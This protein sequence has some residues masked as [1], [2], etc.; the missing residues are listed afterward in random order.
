M[1]IAI[2]LAKPVK[3]NKKIAGAVVAG[4]V[5]GVAIYLVTKMVKEKNADK[6]NK[7]RSTKPKR[8]YAYEYSL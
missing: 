6:R 7:R 5:A 4:I 2:T 1:P 3:M 8:T